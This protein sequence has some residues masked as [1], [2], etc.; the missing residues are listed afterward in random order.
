MSEPSYPHSLAS[1]IAETLCDHEHG[2]G[3][4]RTS[5]LK[6]VYDRLAYKVIDMV[7][8][9]Q[10]PPQDP[11]QHIAARVRI[12]ADIDVIVPVGTPITAEYIQ[13]H[14][15]EV[16]PLDVTYATLFQH[17]D[18]GPRYVTQGQ[19]ATFTGP[20][21]AD[22]MHAQL[23]PVLDRVEQALYDMEDAERSG[24]LPKTV[25]SEGV[26]TALGALHNTLHIVRSRL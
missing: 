3:H 1:A 24:K 2:A 26:W 7:R 9:S 14:W 22:S 19:E 21:T 18:T 25:V 5:S 15:T 13:E 8:D 4:Y 16:V 23:K 11:R 20:V 17:L 12:G 6:S 10:V